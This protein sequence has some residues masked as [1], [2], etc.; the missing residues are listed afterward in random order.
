MKIRSKT[1]IT[2]LVVVM[3]MLIVCG[4]YLA[5]FYRA[6]YESI[7]AFSVE[8][9]IV[10]EKLDKAKTAFIPENPE[11]GFIFYPG[12]KVEHR[13]YE[14]LMEALAAQDILCVLI[15]MPFNLA[16]LDIDAAEEVQEYF[17]EIEKWYIGGHSLGGSMAASYLADNVDEFSG[18]V[19]LA[20]YSTADLS[21]SA[22]DVLSIYGSNDGV[23]NREKYTMYSDML[24]ETF[25][26]LVID[27]ANHAG[28]GMYGQQDGD[29]EAALSNAQQIVLSAKAIAEHINEKTE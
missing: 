10:T 6:D 24:P 11:A 15:E 9:A 26:E 27:E 17:P 5:D 20:S 23:L 7:D 13:A 14:P 2:I 28:F 4:I 12:G 1:I 3:A 8:E 29:G 25:T 19:L 18:L 22:L 21:G 16:V